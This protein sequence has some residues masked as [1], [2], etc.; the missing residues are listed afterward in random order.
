MILYLNF[1]HNHFKFQQWMNHWLGKQYVK[2]QIRL[3]T[4]K[5]GIKLVLHFELPD[6]SSLVRL[7]VHKSKI[8]VTLH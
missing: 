5:Q 4:K 3:V 8:V 1:L 6:S 7:A 2:F